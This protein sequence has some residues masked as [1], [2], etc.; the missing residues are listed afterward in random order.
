MAEVARISNADIR[1]I[2]H[3][4]RRDSGQNEAEQ[5]NSDVSNAVCDG[6]TIECEKHKRF[7]NL[8]S[9]EIAGLTLSDYNMCEELRDKKNAC[10]VACEVALRVD[11]APCIGEYTKGFVAIRSVDGFFGT[12]NIW[13]GF[14]K[15]RVQIQR[16]NSRLLLHEENC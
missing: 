16:K 6:S 8:T 1:I 12:R 10:S 14:I 15:H 3:G 7:K 4:L 13:K 2:L 5:T 9:K 11:G